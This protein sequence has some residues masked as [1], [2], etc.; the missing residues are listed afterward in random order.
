METGY[1]QFGNSFKVVGNVEYDPELGRVDFLPGM[2]AFV[3]KDVAI[4]NHVYANLD[5]HTNSWGL[6]IDL[7]NTQVYLA[8]PSYVQMTDNQGS[9]GSSYFVNTYSYFMNTGLSYELKLYDLAADTYL[10]LAY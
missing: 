7:D 2:E 3:G 1:L 8:H 6:H 4:L 10:P 5:E 9:Y